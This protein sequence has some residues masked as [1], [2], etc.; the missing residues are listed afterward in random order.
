MTNISDKSADI[1]PIRSKD[2]SSLQYNKN[3]HLALMTSF[4][5][6][7]PDGWMVGGRHPKRGRSGEQS[8][9]VF[10]RHHEVNTRPKNTFVRLPLLVQ[11]KN[12]KRHK[13]DGIARLKWSDWWDIQSESEKMSHFL[14]VVLFEVWIL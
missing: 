5:K 12:L 11:K 6:R 8:S 9:I 7:P 13:L 1:K 14:K 3:C 10:D 2:F 4:V